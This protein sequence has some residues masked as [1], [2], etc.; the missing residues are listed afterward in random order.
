MR[1]AEAAAFAQVEGELKSAGYGPP[2]EFD[3]V[4]EVK[5]FRDW[6][7]ELISNG[8]AAQ[9][10][11]DDQFSR[12]K[13]LVD[14]ES[15]DGEVIRSLVHDVRT[16]YWDDRY[17]TLGLSNP[18]DASRR[19]RCE[20]RGCLHGDRWWMSEHGVVQCLH[21]KPPGLPELVVASG[22]LLNAPLVEVDCARQ[23]VDYPKPVI[24]LEPESA[25]PAEP[26][27]AKSRKTS[28]P[29]RK[30]SAGKPPGHALAEQSPVKRLH[31]DC[32]IL[33]A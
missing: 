2:P 17:R 6:L 10:L 31:Q 29:S 18:A 20:N 24:V 26:I 19:W 11:T 1:K 13:N 8:H 12:A 22:D 28:P 23:A 32:F 9:L 21:C 14:R 27:L 16:C 4:P 25:G 7:G 30:T 5:F 3:Y 15:S 33:L